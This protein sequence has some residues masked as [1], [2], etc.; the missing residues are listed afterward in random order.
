MKTL[1]ITFTKAEWHHEQIA[2]EGLRAIYKRWKDSSPAPHYEVILIKEGK[3]FTIKGEDYPATELYPS[4]NDFGVRGW[5]YPTLER[6]Q[7]KYKEL[8]PPTKK[9]VVKKPSVN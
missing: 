9:T 6:S 4:A 7:Q 3:E 8:K 2:R 1:P 5:T